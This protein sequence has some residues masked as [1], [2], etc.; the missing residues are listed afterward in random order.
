[1]TWSFHSA[2]DSAKEKTTADSADS[3]EADE[4]FHGRYPFRK[5]RTMTETARTTSPEISLH[6]VR[7]V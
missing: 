5:W 7:Q 6:P 1:M 3:A 4:L 2:E